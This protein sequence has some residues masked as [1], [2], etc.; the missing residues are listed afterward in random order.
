MEDKQAGEEEKLQ[1]EKEPQQ[2]QQVS[3]MSL[4][5]Q[6]PPASPQP[7]SAHSFTHSVVSATEEKARHQERPSEE[8][9]GR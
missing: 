2:Q 4:K 3:L 5:P 8:G 7:L 9:R 1:K 6:D